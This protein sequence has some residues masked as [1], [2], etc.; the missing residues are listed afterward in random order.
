MFDI[1][2]KNTLKFEISVSKDE[3]EFQTF[4]DMKLDKREKKD[5]A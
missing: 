1:F 5:E 4:Y 3:C 2:W